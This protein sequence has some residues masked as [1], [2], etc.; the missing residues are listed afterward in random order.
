M[1]HGVRF[2]VHKDVNVQNSF[3]MNVCNPMNYSTM[4]VWCQKVDGQQ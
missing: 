2:D 1:G 3:F 4:F